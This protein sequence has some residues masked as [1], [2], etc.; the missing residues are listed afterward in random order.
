[1]RYVALLVALLAISGCEPCRHRDAPDAPEPEPDRP[2]TIPCGICNR[3][4]AVRTPW[5]YSCPVCHALILK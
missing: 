5:G 4:T 1:M 2:P 3:G